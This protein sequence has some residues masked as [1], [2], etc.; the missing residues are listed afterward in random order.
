MDLKLGDKGTLFNTADLNNRIG[1][2]DFLD[3]VPNPCLPSRLLECVRTSRH[4]HRVRT[5]LVHPIRQIRGIT[6]H[7]VT[8]LVVVTLLPLSRA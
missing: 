5:K 2:N 4:K 1:T 6:R 7:G 3:F 8:G